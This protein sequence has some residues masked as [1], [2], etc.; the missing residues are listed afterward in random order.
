MDAAKGVTATFM[1]AQ[2]NNGG[3]LYLPLIR[4]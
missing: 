4:K 2:S 3:R 1:A